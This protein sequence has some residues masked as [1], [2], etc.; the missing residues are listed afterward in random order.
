[1]QCLGVGLTVNAY[2]TGI[3]IGIPRKIHLRD[4]SDAKAVAQSYAQI[5]VWSS[6]SSVALKWSFKFSLFKVHIRLWTE[7][8]HFYNYERILTRW[9]DL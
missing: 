5:S 4:G 9:K 8:E 6:V 1:M 3:E 2:S 7:E